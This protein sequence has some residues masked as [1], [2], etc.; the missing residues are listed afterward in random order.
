VLK[1]I[2]ITSKGVLRLIMKARSKP[3]KLDFN[4][5]ILGRLKTNHPKIPIIQNDYRIK[6][7]GHRGE[8]CLDFFLTYLPEE[9]YFLIQGL[10]LSNGKSHFQM[11]CLIL[12]PT[13]M[14]VIEAK[15][16]KGELKFDEE[17]DQLIQ[18]Y[19]DKQLGFDDPLLQAKFQVRQLI[20][21]LKKHHFPILP[22][23]YLVMM[24]NSSA[25]LITDLGSEARYR[26]CRG[27]RLI[28]RIEE[29]S[30]K[31]QSQRI[32]HK[33]ILKLCSFLLE[34]H[35]EPIYDVERSYNLSHSELLTGVHCSS[36]SHLP[37]VYEQGTWLC[38]RC[39]FKSRMAYV[40]AL[41]DYCLLIAPTIT[42]QQFREFAHCPSMN[43][44]YKMLQPLN[45]PVSGSKKK[46]I[47]HLSLDKF[48]YPPE[49]VR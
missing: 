31:Y 14:L 4:D 37:M 16:M 40:Q 38:P 13:F 19:D 26:V 35:V 36:C 43:A 47:Y 5:A 18:K 20:E 45:L 23:E 10:R 9:N 27:R 33:S 34:K 6:E 39:K 8:E 12:T 49:K 41:R 32:T 24:S 22:V 44:A 17:H 15:N 42:T 29:F 3:S 11:D 7:A 2:N 30:S 28:Y 46:R 48:I 1:T 25:V 21:F